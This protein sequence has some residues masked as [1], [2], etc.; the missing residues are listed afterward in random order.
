M[1]RAPRSTQT[2]QWHMTKKEREQ[3]ERAEESLS[4][5]RPL[6][7]WGPPSKPKSRKWHFAR[8]KQLL[9]EVG[10]DDAFY[11][12]PI[13]RY[14]DLLIECDQIK[15]EMAHTTSAIDELEQQKQGMEYVE[16]LELYAELHRAH[17]QLHK[18]LDRKRNMLL[19]IEKENLM[20]VLSK[21]RAVLR[22]IPEQE[23]TDPMED[24]L[25]HRPTLK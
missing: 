18:L 24:L 3:R 12:A 6:T 22:K 21:Q 7:Y 16:W 1:G 5:E 25:G 8:V 20:T 9:A 2:S 11:T 4:P 19:A 10:E 17:A 13:N 23:N 15:R 14:C